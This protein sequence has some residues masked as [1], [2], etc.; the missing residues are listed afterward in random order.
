MSH[1]DFEKV[2]QAKNKTPEQQ[3]VVDVLRG[4]RS[5]RDFVREFGKGKT[6]NDLVKQVLHAEGTDCPVKETKK[7]GTVEYYSLS[8]ITSKKDGKLSPEGKAFYSWVQLSTEERAKC[9]DTFYFV[10]VARSMKANMTQ[11]YEFDK[12]KKFRFRKTGEPVT[13]IPSGKGSGSGKEPTR[14]VDEIYKA[15]QTAFDID[16]AKLK[17]AELVIVRTT[18]LRILDNMNIDKNLPEVTGI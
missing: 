18:L 13:K 17:P 14:K 10:L 3:L 7:D 12:D 6:V 9:T 4:E 8:H 16:R 1:F 15:V 2:L 5:L 11:L